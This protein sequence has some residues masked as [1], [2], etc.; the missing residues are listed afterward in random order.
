[1]HTKLST[2]DAALDI[3]KREEDVLKNRKIF[4]P[5]FEALEKSF[6]VV[7]LTIF[8]WKDISFDQHM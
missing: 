6:K 4:V 7:F 1:M 3:E 8:F 5:E 2:C